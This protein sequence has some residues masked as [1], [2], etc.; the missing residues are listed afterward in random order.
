[1]FPSGL[2]MLP[3]HQSNRLA[4]KN[5]N[6]THEKLPFKLLVGVLQEIPKIVYAIAVALSCI[7]EA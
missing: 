7:P 5:P 1:M 6:S 2:T 3:L 4:N